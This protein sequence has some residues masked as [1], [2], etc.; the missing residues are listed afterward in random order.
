[1]PHLWPPMA[2]PK[3]HT[4]QGV[5]AIVKAISSSLQP[6]PIAPG[7]SSTRA[8]SMGTRVQHPS[9]MITDRFVQPKCQS[10]CQCSCTIAIAKADWVQ[11]QIQPQ[12]KLVHPPRISQCIRGQGQRPAPPS[13][14]NSHPQKW[15]SGDLPIVCLRHIIGL[16]TFIKESL[17]IKRTL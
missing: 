4:R 12:A 11:R 7:K 1:M 3:G 16:M 9:C 10:Q 8:T 14:T 2:S 17:T 6:T 15:C 13:T 5:I